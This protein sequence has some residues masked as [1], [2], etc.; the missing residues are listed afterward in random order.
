MGSAP[1]YEERLLWAAAAVCFF[2]FFSTGEITAS[3]TSAVDQSLHLACGDV[4]ISGD[5]RSYTSS[6]CGRMASENRSIRPGHG[7]ILFVG[8]THDELCLIQAIRSYVAVHG[9]SPA[10]VRSEFV[11]CA[12]TLLW[13]RRKYSKCGNNQS[14]YSSSGNGGRTIATDRSHARPR[15]YTISW[16]RFRACALT[17]CQLETAV[18]CYVTCAELF[19]AL[20]RGVYSVI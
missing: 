9:E 11:Y 8:A 10:A 5:N 3:S 17:E 4:S 13:P 6:S 14:D 15:C 18:T 19:A 1:G 2:G 7:G 20:L 12:N 16:V